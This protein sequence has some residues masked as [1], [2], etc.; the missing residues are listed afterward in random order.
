MTQP[1]EPKVIPRRVGCFGWLLRIGGGILAILVLL[2]I[3]SAV[4]QQIAS[5]NDRAAFPAPGKLVEV[6]G[7]M[8][9]LLC[10]GE[11]SPTV[12]L[13]AGNASFSLDWSL[14]QPDVAGSTRVCS[15]DR[16]GYGW[17]DVS[18]EVRDGEHAARELHGLL[19]AAG[20]QGPYVLVGH[21]LGGYFVRSF[22][23]AYP[24][25]VAGLILIE[26]P[27]ETYAYQ[28]DA[29]Q[30]MVASQQGFYGTMGFLTGS[31]LLRVIAPL[32]GEQSIPAHIAALPSEVQGSYLSIVSRPELYQTAA[33][34]IAA[35]PET[36]RQLSGQTLGDLPL[37][38]LGAEFPF[39]QFGDPSISESFGPPAQPA[40]PAMNADAHKAQEELAR[41]SS[42]GT[43]MLVEGSGHLIPT[44]KPQAVI[45]AILKM[46]EELRAE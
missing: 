25:Q 21:S 11:G 41:L 45:D 1:T 39:Q 20:E 6:D 7:R 38:V 24:D 3:A 15:Y 16:A 14:V 46:V 2:L 13:D 19:E 31:G 23:R 10:S 5:Q 37:T 35:A 42:K 9:H 28:G 27:N 22:A 26:S 18:P 36:T 33:A 12:I 44:D 40:T 8:M 34:E 29:S 17:S 32:I 4:N 30:Q 43:F